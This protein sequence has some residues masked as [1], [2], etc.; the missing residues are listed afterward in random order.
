M[1]IEGVSCLLTSFA[2][3]SD[4]DIKFIGLAYHIDNTIQY[5]KCM[6]RAHYNKCSPLPK[7][8]STA[9]RYQLERT[10]YDKGM[11]WYAGPT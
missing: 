10:R 5:D 11:S 3:V 4:L 8:N 6:V 2:Y 7:D 1:E 9:H